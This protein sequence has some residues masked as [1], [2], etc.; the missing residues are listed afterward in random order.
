VED[1]VVYLYNFRLGRNISSY[2]TCCASMNGIAPEIVRRADELILIAARGGDLVSACAKMPAEDARELEEAEKVARDFLAADVGVESD[3]D[4]RKLLEEILS[5][6][7]TTV[8]RSKWASIE[9]EMFDTTTTD[10]G[11]EDTTTS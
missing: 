8:G 3:V 11:I 6:S 5:V 1:Q 10:Y 4:A 2:G 9:H 7:E